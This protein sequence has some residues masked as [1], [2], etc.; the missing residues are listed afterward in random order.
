MSWDAAI[1]GTLTLPPLHVDAWLRREALSASVPNAEKYLSLVELDGQ[2]VKKTLAQIEKFKD[3][4]GLGFIDISRGSKPGHFEVRSFLCKDDYLHYSVHL[5]A[6]WAAATEGLGELYFS[7]MLTAGF[8]Q[9]L[10]VAKRGVTLKELTGNPA[11]KLP[12]YQEILARVNARVAE[13]GLG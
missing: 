12:A 6:V 13:L 7:G 10:T 2:T 11:R 1:F 8:C 5:A 4:E 3:K 9:K